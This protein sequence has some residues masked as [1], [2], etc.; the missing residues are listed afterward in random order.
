MS[1]S[2]CFGLAYVRTMENG[3]LFYPD[4]QGVGKFALTLFIDN[5]VES[6]ST[7]P[8]LCIWLCDS[9]LKS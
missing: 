4:I 8:L 6:P 5:P 7:E 3:L 1:S 2:V 9:E